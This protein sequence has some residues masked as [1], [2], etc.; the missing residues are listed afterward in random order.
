MVARRR[1]PGLI[2]GDRLL[3]VSLVLITRATRSASAS[4]TDPQLS[5]PPE[6]GRESPGSPA[7]TLTLAL[8]VIGEDAGWAI[9]MITSCR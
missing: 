7:G 1:G 8:V 6:C 4:A 2:I 5:R 9:F 3:V